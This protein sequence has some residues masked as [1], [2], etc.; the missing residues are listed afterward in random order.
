T[1]T[2]PETSTNG[3]P[4]SPRSLPSS[5]SSRRRSRPAYAGRRCATASVEACARCAEPKASF[6]YRSHPSARRR[7]VSGSFFVSPGSKRVFSST[8]IRSS[9]RSSRSRCRTGSLSY[10]GSCSF[11]RPRWEQTRISPASRSIRSRSVGS[12]ARIRVSSATRRSSSGT[13][14]SERTRT[15]LSRTSALSTDRGRRKLEQPVDQVGQARRVAP[16]VVV[17]ADHLDLVPVRHRREPVDDAG[18]RV[19]DDV[20]GDDRILR[21]LEDPVPAVRAGRAAERLVHV[22]LRR[23]PTEDAHEVGDAPVRDGHAHRHPVELALELG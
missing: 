19:P 14:R 8:A 21:V 18:R 16:L 2:P 9:G 4:T 5:S 7:A 1:L 11:G 12:E 13:F 15:C 22:V 20:R 3:R 6:T 17:P 10:A 23:L